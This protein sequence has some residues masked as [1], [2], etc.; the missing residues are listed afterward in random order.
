MS[1]ISN[2]IPFSPSKL[3]VYFLLLL[4]VLSLESCMSNRKA[5]SQWIGA[6]QNE[7]IEKWGEPDRVEKDGLNAIW[8]YDRFNSQFPGTTRTKSASGGEGA[9]EYDQVS[10]VKFIIG[11]NRTIANYELVHADDEL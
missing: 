7:L 6:N 9:S 4:A 10:A 11:P 1:I 3:K 2:K 5:L 8:I